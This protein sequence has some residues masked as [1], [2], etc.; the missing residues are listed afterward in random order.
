MSIAGPRL[1]KGGLHSGEHVQFPELLVFWYPGHEDAL[2]LDRLIAR[3]T[4]PSLMVP[5][6]E[7]GKRIRRPDRYPLQKLAG[8]FACA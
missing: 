7:D 6:P 8:S 3:D 2:K 1:P 4:E 5:C